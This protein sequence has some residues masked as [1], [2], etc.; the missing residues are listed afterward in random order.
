MQQQGRDEEALK[1]YQEALALAPSNPMT[2]NNLALL[3]K[4]KGEFREAQRLLQ[5]GLKYSNDVPE[6]H[7]N[8]A[9]L[10]ELYLLDLDAALTHYQAY[11]TSAGLE[12][13]KVKG[14]IADLERRLQ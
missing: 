4:A 3:L 13:G 9:V 7:Y 12:D 10:S 6:L 11:Q 5:E 8:L 14:W 1:L 2:I